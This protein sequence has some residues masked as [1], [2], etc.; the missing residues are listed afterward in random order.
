[1][2]LWSL[3]NYAVLKRLFVMGQSKESLL[4][5]LRENCS[6]KDRN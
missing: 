5:E 2:T 3:L 1:M 6:G 4:E